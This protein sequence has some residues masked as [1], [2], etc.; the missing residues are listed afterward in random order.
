MRKKSSLVFFEK[1]WYQIY[2]VIKMNSMKRDFLLDC[3]FENA[4]SNADRIGLFQRIYIRGER[5]ILSNVNG[6]FDI[7][8]GT[9][10]DKTDCSVRTMIECTYVTAE[11]LE[12]AARVL[13][14]FPEGSQLVFSHSLSEEE[15]YTK[16]SPYGIKIFEY[17]NI[18]AVA[19]AMGDDNEH[20]EE[21]Y[22]CL[23]VKN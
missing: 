10:S 5:V 14:R 17:V 15:C 8:Y 4:R 13:C 6:N 2:E 12:T 21:R 11:E 9:D 16:L 7:T 19:R 22:Y 23:A 1:L 20:A 3:M 18:S